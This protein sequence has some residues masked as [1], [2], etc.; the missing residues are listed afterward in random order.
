MINRKIKNATKVEFDWIKFDSK[1]ELYCYKALREAKIP[2]ELKK[3]FVSVEKFRYMWESIREI[4]HYPDFFLYDHNIILDTKGFANDTYPIKTKILKKHLYDA[5]KEYKIITV[6]NQKEVN[7]FI[8]T[9][10]LLNHL[11]TK[12]KEWTQATK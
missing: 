6:K 1:L 3:K 11:W 8:K 12:N 9:L 7:E 5:W 10:T 2:F 4:A